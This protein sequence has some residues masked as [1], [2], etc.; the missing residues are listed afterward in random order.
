MLLQATTHANK[1]LQLA[2]LIQSAVRVP[3]PTL[4]GFVAVCQRRPPRPPPP[5]QAT[6]LSP[7]HGLARPR[8]PR[9]RAPQPPKGA[10]KEIHTF[11]L[12]EEIITPSSRQVTMRRGVFPKIRWIGSFWLAI[13]GQ[14][15]TLKA[16]C[17]LTSTPETPW[18]WRQRIVCG[19][20][21]PQSR[22]GTMWRK[23]SFCRQMV[24]ILRWRKLAKMLRTSW[25]RNLQSCWRWLRSMVLGKLQG[26]WPIASLVIIWTS[27]SACLRRIFDSQ[28]F[29]G[30]FSY[31]GTNYY[32][33]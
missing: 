33:V 26:L 24:Q 6:R 29:V 3:F 17:F 22:S 19:G 18:K 15:S 2:L 23:Q 13:P 4:N 21:K 14:D 7:R 28:W 25:R 9:P 10:A 31:I 32:F 20:P 12:C 27:K 30:H 11:K 16:C 1:Q 5:P 8:P